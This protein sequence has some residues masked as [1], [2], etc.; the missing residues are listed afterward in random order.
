MCEYLPS[1][2]LTNIVPLIND[3]DDAMDSILDEIF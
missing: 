1:N 2:L 3:I